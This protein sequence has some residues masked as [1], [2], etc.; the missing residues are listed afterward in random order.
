M[1]RTALML[2]LLTLPTAALSDRALPNI[3]SVKLFG[4]CNAGENTEVITTNSFPGREDGKDFFQ[5]TFDDMVIE[6]S[7]AKGERRAI[8]DCYAELDVDLPSGYTIGNLELEYDGT[9]ELGAKSFGI[10]DVYVTIP[11]LTDRPWNNTQYKRTKKVGPISEDEDGDYST[12][13]VSHWGEL[14]GQR[15]PD[16]VKI[17]VDILTTLRTSRYADPDDAN[18]VTVDVMSGLFKTDSADISLVPC[19]RKQQHYSWWSWWWF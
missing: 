18:Q 15:C 14:P 10:V 11:E 7:S 12:T 17:Y 13:F 2:S 19:E 6:G 8:K 1:L 4:A 3:T 5:F 9:M 16:S